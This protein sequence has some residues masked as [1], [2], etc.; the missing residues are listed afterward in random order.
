M[1]KA[2]NVETAENRKAFLGCFQRKQNDCNEWR[3]AA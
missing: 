1:E 2:Q 3:D